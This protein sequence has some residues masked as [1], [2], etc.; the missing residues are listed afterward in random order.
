MW[1]P[2][3]GNQNQ[4]QVYREN[5]MKHIVNDIEGVNEPVEFNNNIIGNYSAE[6]FLGNFNAQPSPFFD[7]AVVS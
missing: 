1:L 7:N 3:N 4:I 6:L 2:Y 5:L